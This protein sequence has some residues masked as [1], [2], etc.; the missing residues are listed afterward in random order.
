MKTLELL[1]NYHNEDP[2]AFGLKMADALSIGTAY[3][4]ELKTLL[5]ELPSDSWNLGGLFAN[6]LDTL[7]SDD[8]RELGALLDVR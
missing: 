4:R 3:V 2:E 1:A 8:L 7:S 5:E 6:I